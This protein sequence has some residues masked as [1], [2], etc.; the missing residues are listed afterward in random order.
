M[1]D[2]RSALQ[3]PALT[4]SVVT[5]VASV[6]PAF[7]TGALGVQLRDALGF[8]A[9]G[10]GFAVAS[11]FVV[12]VVGSAALGRLGE[13]LGARHA[14]TI[15]LCTTIL[16]N[17]VIATWADRWLTLAIPLMA[18]GAANA[19]NQTAANSLLGRTSADDR[20][21][22]SV[23]VKQAG[24]PAATLLGGLAVPGIAQTAGWRW[25]YV[26]AA[27][28]ALGALAIVRR[29]DPT[30][31][32]GPAGPASRPDLDPITFLVL[33]T[34]VAFGA[35]MAGALASWTV[36]SAEAAGLS[37]GAAGLLLAGGSA[38]GITSRLLMGD[39]ADRRSGP[40]L[41]VVARMML[42]GAAGLVVL[43]A[44]T[45]ASAML[46]TAVGF[47]AGWAWPGLFNGTIVALNP[48]APGAATG[49][50]QTGTYLGVVVGPVVTGVLV[51]G[52]GYASAWLVAALSG[53]IAAGLMLVGQQRLR[54]QNG[55]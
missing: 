44:G 19:L 50:T 37:A 15:G 17:L 53:V 20:L 51:D 25:A 18:A 3:W 2:S 47:G 14:M 5:T 28:V 12:G 13:R 40:T 39:R 7:L 16:A 54:H 43:A 29:A 36:S 45:P 32:A 24:M 33:A 35:Y 46:G 6:L 8:D 38:L 22:F 4:M 41:P 55:P 48:S 11:F 34:A 1:T 31:R 27:A 26:A 9:T 42:F 21:I 10:L 49:I 30:G 52:P 23:S